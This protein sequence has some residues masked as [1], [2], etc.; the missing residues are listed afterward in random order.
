MMRQSMLTRF[1]ECFRKQLTLFT[2]CGH[3]ATLA[4]IWSYVSSNLMVGFF[5]YS[6]H[7]KSN[8]NSLLFQSHMVLF[9]RNV[10][11]CFGYIVIADLCMIVPQFDVFI[12]N[13][14]RLAGQEHGSQ[15]LA[16]KA[17]LRGQ[18]MKHCPFLFDEIKS[19]IYN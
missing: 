1:G 12:L 6:L 16:Y 4:F 3:G 2:F 7:D 18:V 13:P 5:I 14:C 10:K 19:I 9:F 17:P 15:M 8:Q 11:H